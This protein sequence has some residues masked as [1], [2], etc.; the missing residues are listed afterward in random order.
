MFVNC[1]Y[2]KQL[3]KFN[4]EPENDGFQEKCP[5]SPDFRV[6]HMKLQDFISDHSV[7][8]NVL[9]V[10]AT[11]TNLWWEFW[12]IRR[13]VSAAKNPRVPGFRLDLFFSNKKE[14]NS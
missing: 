5:F 1:V 2:I 13:H 12:R 14:R 11:S 3:P 10:F 6:N 7:H 8:S 9:G 4:M